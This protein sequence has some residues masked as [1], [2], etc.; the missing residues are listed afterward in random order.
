L[1]QFAWKDNAEMIVLRVDG[2]SGQSST[3]SLVLAVLL[4][5]V[6][7]VILAVL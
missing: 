7:A 1:S 2:G 3:D 6:K 4:A 5:F